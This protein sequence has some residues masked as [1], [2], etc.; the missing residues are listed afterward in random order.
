MRRRLHWRR[1]MRPTWGR[2]AVQYEDPWKPGVWK[3]GWDRRFFTKSGALIFMTEQ[4]STSPPWK[5]RVLNK[6]TGQA[7]Y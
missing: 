7:I 1:L 4:E 3:D 5:L 6:Y 2:W